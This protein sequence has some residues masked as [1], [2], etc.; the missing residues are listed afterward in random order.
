MKISKNMIK[1]KNID[2][3]NPE[4]KKA[5]NKELFDEVAPKYNFITKVLSFGRDSSWKKILIL[6]LPDKKNPFCLDLACGTGDIT[7]ALSKKYNAGNITGLDL[8]D[9]MLQYAQKIN[10]QENIKFKIG[11]MNQ[12]G[13]KENQFDIITGGYALRNAPSVNKT[14]CEIHKILKKGGYAAFLDFSKSPNKIIQRISLFFLKL[15]GSIWGILA[16]GNPDIYGYIA[17]SLKNFPDRKKLKELI[18]QTG[19]KNIN[20]KILFFGFLEI[21]TFEK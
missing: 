10:V 20:S 6:L 1:M 4:N 7:F 9:K 18:L 2:F 14:L 13:F 8:N 11:D 12:T 5:F 15:W 16:H 17:E 3:D 19:F 21:I